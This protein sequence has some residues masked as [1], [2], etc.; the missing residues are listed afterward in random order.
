MGRRVSQPGMEFS[1][2]LTSSRLKSRLGSCLQAAGLLEFWKDV[3][4]GKEGGNFVNFFLQK[5]PF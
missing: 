2:K 5:V 4:K 3:K 1:G